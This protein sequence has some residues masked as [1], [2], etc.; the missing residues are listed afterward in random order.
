MSRTLKLVFIVALFAAILCGQEFLAS[1]SGRVT[2]SSG[3]AVADAKVELLSLATGQRSTTTTDSDGRYLLLSLSPGQYDVTVEKAG[4]SRAVN[5]GMKLDVAQKAQLDITMTVGDVKQTIE[6]TAN[7]SVVQS[8]S[9]DHGLTIDN[10]RVQNAPLQGRNIFA[11]AWSAP[12]VAVTGSVTRLRPFDTG[13]SSGMSINGGRPSMNEVLID[14]VSNLNPSGLAVAYVPPVDSTEEFRVQTTN[15]DA[16]YGWTTGGVV[17]VLTKSGTNDY[18]GGLYEYLQNTHLNANT[19]GSN[20]S[21]VGR[22]SSHINT[23]GGNIGGPVKKNKLFFYFGYEDLR[24]VIPD[25]FVTS[26]PSALQ[27]QGNFSQTYYATATDGTP[28]QQT[29]YNPFS[30]H[31]DASS[32][33]LVRDAFAGNVIPTSMLNP[34]ALKTLGLI[35]SGN[36]VGNAITGL[37]NLSNNGSTRKFTDFFP[38]YLYRADY[39]VSESTKMFFR[40][41]QNALSEERGF[42]YSTVS[43]LNPADTSGNAPFTRN[44]NS[45]T[46]QFTHVLSPTAVLELRAGL[47]RFI[48]QSG[49]SLGAGYDLSGLGFSP[50]FVG[51]AG[52]YFPKFNW[53]NYEGAGSNP[54]QITPASTTQSYQGM[55]SKT[56]SRQTLKFGG[57]YRL[58]RVNTKSPG[59]IAGNFT[60]DQTFTG[61]DPVTIQPSSGNSIASFLL[62]TPQ[63][64]YIN[65]NS[66]PARQ[67]NMFSAF[68][69]DDIRLSPRL[70]INVGLRWDYMGPMTDRYDALTRG[71]DTTSAS[72]LQ[73]PGLNL[74]GGLLYVDENG[75]PKGAYNR[76]W[77]NIG[78]RAGFAYRFNEK[79]VIRGGY[80]LFY[81]NIYNDPGNAPGFSQQT[82]MVTS[83]QSGVP[84]DTLT[85][86]F[87][88]GILQPVGASQGLATNIGQTFSFADPS[89]K[90]PYVQQYSL[91]VQRE[92]PFRLLA[93]VGYVGSRSRRLD[94]TQSIKEV[95]AQSL[96]LGTMQLTASVANPFAGLVP[97]TS[98]NGATIQQQ[99]LLRP[100]PQFLTLQ[101]QNRPIGKSK[102]D[103]LQLSLAKRMSDLSVSVSYT[104]SK[105]IDWTN[106]AN[107][108]DSALEKV[109][110][111]WDVTN[112]LQINGFYELPFGRGKRFG[113]ELPSA[114]R[115]LASGWQVSALARIQSGMPMA[116]PTNAV[117]TGASPVLDNQNL[118]RWFNTCTELANK[119][120]RGC[121][122]GETPVWSIRPS[123]TLQK[124]SS[125][126]SSV[127]LPGIH[128]LD[129]SVMKS[130]RLTERTDLVFRVDFI[131]AL[132]TP[133]FYNGPNV[134]VNSANFGHISGVSDQSN[135]PR[136]VQLSLKLQF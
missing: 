126:L 95:S 124:W 94:V 24:Q 50:Q 102:Y 13:G 56:I 73:V 39:Q 45:A 19:F 116:F 41:G 8:E 20:R 23:F 90:L 123:L 46:A 9:A 3:G 62:G 21:G 33:K 1:I 51:L 2:D 48:S 14:G 98:L 130:N 128:N 120:T 17:N 75:Q 134:D 72:P 83:I 18:H 115:Y 81:A 76:N 135:L 37:N 74:K 53:A 6:V 43:A 117:P 47:L 101:E 86:P 129:A 114:V 91:Q 52:S 109:I 82:S 99:Q 97:G 87:P 59:Y 121:L 35:P 32:G 64:G 15:F 92:L 22:Q 65:V 70:T 88:S 58:E 111:K 26:V 127:R 89:G 107:P 110:A 119:T 38:E 61:Q 80:G 63:S 104:Y 96:A 29:I 28:L 103:G 4:F 60:F 112:S 105:T 54:V 106:F 11:A 132:N 66:Q 93:S 67:Q 30:T 136:F 113:G 100:F 125:Y 133:Q 118:D 68:T 77:N 84:A 49:S 12:G 57:E 79:T 36:V 122:S 25:P 85:N 44:N 27:R 78:P 31:T 108:Q 40:Y 7:A 5:Q 34:I 69:Q 71:F 16:Q 10:V 42:H 131:N 55:L